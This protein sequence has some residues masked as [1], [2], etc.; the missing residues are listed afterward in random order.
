VYGSRSGTPGLEA[1]DQVLR[2]R[3]LMMQREDQ[4]QFTPVMQNLP[5]GIGA[6]RINREA[7]V[8]VLHEF[9]PEGVGLL[10]TVDPA[11]AQFPDQ[12]VMEYLVDPED[13]M[14]IRM[15]RDW[16]TQLL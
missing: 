10:R 9:R 2:E 15:D 11:Q 16:T 4:G 6:L 13:A 5:V 3:A 1:A 14:P 7:G 8:I 12:A